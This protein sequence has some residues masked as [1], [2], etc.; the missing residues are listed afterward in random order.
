MHMNRRSWRG[1][2]TSL[3]ACA[4]LAACSG[5][6]EKTGEPIAIVAMATA[7]KAGPSKAARAGE[8]ATALVN[9]EG[10]KGVDRITPG[11]PRT[12]TLATSDGKMDNG[13]FVL[14][15]SGDS[16]HYQLT[17]IIRIQHLRRVEITATQLVVRFQRAGRRGWL[18]INAITLGA[19]DLLEPAWKSLR[20]A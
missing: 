2:L 14:R 10:Q 3:L 7:Q 17:P 20:G 9:G 6:P 4:A 11:Q 18:A 16:R 13:A 19:Q 5:E 15:Q 1:A 8:A 12:G